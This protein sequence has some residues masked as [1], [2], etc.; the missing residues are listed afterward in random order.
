MND[1]QFKL[2]KMQG[3]FVWHSHEDTDE[4]FIVVK[5]RMEIG[6]RDR[7]VVLGEGEMLRDP[8]RRRA[9]HPRARGVPCA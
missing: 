3:D 9:H 7:D 1:V 4:V 2:V 6:F 8:A 5:G